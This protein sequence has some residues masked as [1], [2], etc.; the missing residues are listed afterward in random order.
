[1]TGEISLKRFMKKQNVQ[2]SSQIVS[3]LL[4]KKTG[5]NGFSNALGTRK[6][7]TSGQKLKPR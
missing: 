4:T 2:G 3:F 6:T 7:K 5:I 1:M